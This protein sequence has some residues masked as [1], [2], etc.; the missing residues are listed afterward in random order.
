MEEVFLSS[1]R[2]DSKRKSG[3]VPSTPRKKLRGSE[4]G[5]P[6]L[7][8]KH[9]LFSFDRA[10][11]ANTMPSASVLSNSVV[12]VVVSA[13]SSVQSTAPAEEKVS[14]RYLLYLSRQK[15]AVAKKSKISTSILKKCLIRNT[16]HYLELALMS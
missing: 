2:E 11:S 4:Y 9:K 7:N 15:L 1:G 12:G 14:I 13:P 10:L 16:M 6:Q 3:E 8:C 5:S